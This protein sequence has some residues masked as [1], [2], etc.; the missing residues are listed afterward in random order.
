MNTRRIA[1]ALAWA[2]VAFHL[3]A[4]FSNLSF[5]SSSESE[6]DSADGLVVTLLLLAAPLVPYAICLLIVRIAANPILVLPAVAA[7]LILDIDTYLAVK[8]SV[9][10]TAAISL[11]LA[12]ILNLI[13]VLPLGIAVGW[14]LTRF[15]PFKTPKRKNRKSLETEPMNET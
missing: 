9:S 1:I 10:S 8:S 5:S 6:S 2:G 14:L 15:G 12:P 7:A 3:F 13:L 11:V 4:V